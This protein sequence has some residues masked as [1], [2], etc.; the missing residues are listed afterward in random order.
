MENTVPE[1]Y[2]LKMF[3]NVITPQMP[4]EKQEMLL[5]NVVKNY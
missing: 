3:H 2:L 1:K 5:S 4:N